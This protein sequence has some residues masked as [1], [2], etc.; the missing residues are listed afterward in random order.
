MSRLADRRFAMG[1][2]AVGVFGSSEAHADSLH[3]TAE[4]ATAAHAAASRVTSTGPHHVRLALSPA[5]DRL[6]AEL[7]VRRLLAVELGRRIQLEREATGP[8]EDELVQVWIDLSETRVAL[9]VRR[10]GRPLARRSLDVTGM[11]AELAAHLVAIEASEMVRVQVGA[12]PPDPCGSCRLRAPSPAEPFAGLSVA[13]GAATRWLPSARGGTDEIASTTADPSL[14]LG[15]TLEVGQRIGPLRQFLRGE[16]LGA[17]GSSSRWFGATL[18][19]EAQLPWRA[20]PATVLPGDVRFG[21]G[22]AASVAALD[23]RGERPQDDWL[24]S[25]SGRFSVQVAARR[26]VWL[27]LALEPGAVLRPID[28][29]VAGFMLGA[30]LSLAAG[31]TR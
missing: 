1:L 25:A 9:Q 10:T 5:A 17:G 20:A 28:E 12:V 8:L 3:V 14:F 15:T 11:P 4:T 18:G 2:F 23:I 27:G 24:A 30:G 26:G 6:L 31:P 7:R 29:R 19:L 13:A 21:I 22:V 16:W